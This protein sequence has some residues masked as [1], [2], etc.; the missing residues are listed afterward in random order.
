MSSESNAQQDPSMEEILAS[1]RRII[2][3]GDEAPD[4]EAQEQQQAE[5]ADAQAAPEE[6]AAEPEPETVA[7][8]E[9]EPE[10]VEEEEEVLELTEVVSEEE[11]P[12]G[13]ED[14]ELELIEEESQAQGEG[15]EVETETVVEL[16]PEAK[17]AEE[18]QGG[19]IATTED[20][21]LVSDDTAAVSSDA[22]AELAQSVAAADVRQDTSPLIAQGNSRTLEDVVREAIRP[23]LK[24]WLDKNLPSLVHHLVKKEI[25]RLSRH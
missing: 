12:A 2:S 24:D 22:F 20:D 21:H 5:A 16:E 17:E 15:E 1:I 14:V 19:E 9:P 13:E 6:A 18:T 4:G 23:L 7:E 8:A 25:E 3:E 10:A 11:A